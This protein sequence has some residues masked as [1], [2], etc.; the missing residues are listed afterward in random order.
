VTLV[1]GWGEWT[2]PGPDASERRNAVSVVVRLE[3]RGG[4]VLFTGD[5]VGRRRDDHDSVCKDAERRMVD[6]AANVPIASDVLLG[7]HHGGNNAS[8]TCFIREVDPT[9]VIFSAGHD[10]EHPRALAANRYLALGVPLANIFRTD[11]G[12][13]EG[14]DEWDHGRVSGCSDGRSDDDVDVV[15]RADGSVEV[16]YRQASGGCP[17]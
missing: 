3:Y 16:E 12:D 4:S 14:G 6:N 13:D 8:A 15:L 7:P 2:K 11:R 10:H 5:T 9:F 1:A 17:N